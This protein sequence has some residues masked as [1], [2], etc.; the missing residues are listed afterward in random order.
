MR[1]SEAL[2]LF[3]LL[4]QHPLEFYDQLKTRLEVGLEQ[5]LL[6]PP[7]YQ[8]S[9]WQ[10]VIAGMEKC[11]TV[12]MESLR[13]EPALA[14]IESAVHKGIQEILPR[15]AFALSCN[16]DFTLARLCYLVC[17]AMT[18]AIVLE[19]GVAY[20]VTSAF[21]LQALTV[22]GHGLLH[23]IDRPPFGP[24][25]DQIVGIL[26][27][28]ALKRCWQLHRG[29]SKRILPRLLSQLGQVDVFLHDSR[30]TYRNMRRELLTVSP[31]L[32]P[33]AVV[34]ADDVDR[35]A[36]FSEWV[37]QAQP[38]FSATIQ[39][40]GKKSLFGVSVLL[41]PQGESSVLYNAS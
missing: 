1:I 21:I 37:A 14:D 9:Q 33:R 35:N 8:P 10:E 24:Q 25:A 12:G 23:S 11:L 30:H 29:T 28:P 32:P 41:A 22:N 39:E 3:S 20:G 18:P 36:A 6:Q 34:M 31:Y 16:A 27:P 2:R 5:F 4:P 40:R 17:R 7:A 38:A 13:D 19:T 15:A 26:I